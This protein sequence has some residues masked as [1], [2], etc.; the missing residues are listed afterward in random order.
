MTRALL[1]Q[2]EDYKIACELRKYITEIE[3]R[4][5][6]SVEVHKWIEWAKQ[7]ANWYDPTLNHEDDILGKRDHSKEKDEKS[8]LLEIQDNYY[9][10]FRF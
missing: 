10:E 8:K 1:N 5:D 4:S 7:K 2:A 3:E 6:G 9:R